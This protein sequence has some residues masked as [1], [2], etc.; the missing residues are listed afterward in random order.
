DQLQ[1]HASVACY[2]VEIAAASGEVLRTIELFTCDDPPPIHATNSYASPTPAS[3]GQRML[4][5]FGSLGTACIEMASGQV[6]WKQRFS[7]DEITGPGSSP[8]LAAGVVILP[9]D[10]A[11]QQF[12]IG[13]DIRTG[14]TVWKT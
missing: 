2:A 11:D 14:A 7:F 6:L 10:G 1:V 3:D 13:L 12:V 4:C 5:H 9:C 8:A